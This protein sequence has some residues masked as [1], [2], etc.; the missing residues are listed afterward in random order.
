MW[1]GRGWTQFFQI[2]YINPELHEAKLSL[3]IPWDAWMSEKPWKW[4]FCYVSSYPLYQIDSSGRSLIQECMH[5]YTLDSLC[6]EASCFR[7]SFIRKNNITAIVLEIWNWVSERPF[8][9]RGHSGAW[10][11]ARHLWGYPW[12]SSSSR[13]WAAQEGEVLMSGRCEAF[14]SLFCTN[15][16]MYSP[17][18]LVLWDEILRVFLYS[19]IFPPLIFIFSVLPS[20]LCLIYL[21]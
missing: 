5:P 3:S 11:A 2:T 17:Y 6:V 18:K 15:S 9:C 19:L 14:E 16:S 20:A 7:I 13:S 12:A 8:V 1:R 21:W 4:Y 10:W